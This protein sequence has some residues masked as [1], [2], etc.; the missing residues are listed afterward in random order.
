MKKLYTLLFTAAAFSVI[1][2]Q[3][4]PDDTYSGNGQANVNPTND[5]QSYNMDLKEMISL[6]G[7]QAVSM[8]LFQDQNTWE[9]WTEI[10][11]QIEDNGS[12]NESLYYQWTS[13]EGVVEGFSMDKVSTGIMLAGRI[14][15]GNQSTEIEMAKLDGNLSATGALDNTFG[16]NGKLLIPDFDG[17][18]IPVKVLEHSDGSFFL[19]TEVGIPNSW[20]RKIGISKITAAGVVDNT[21]GTNGHVTHIVGDSLISVNDALI[22]EN[23]NVYVG[24]TLYRYGSYDSGEGIFQFTSQRAFVARFLEDGTL[25]NS[26]SNDGYQSVSFGSPSRWSRLTNLAFFSN[27]EVLLTGNV[28][29]P[30]GSNNSYLVPGY[31]KFTSNGSYNSSFGPNNNGHFTSNFGANRAS[32]NEAIIVGNDNILSLG[33]VQETTNFPYLPAIFVMD[34]DGAALTTYHQDGYYLYSAEGE[35]MREIAETTDS[36]ILT[37]G[38]IY[39]Q[40]SMWT[41]TST[42]RFIYDGV[43]NLST[44]EIA[45]SVYPNPARD[46]LNIASSHNLEKVTIIGMDGKIARTFNNATSL[47]VEGIAPGSYILIGKTLSGEITRQKIIVE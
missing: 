8:H 33:S 37:Y 1:G 7:T 32:N 40:G 20:N 29:I 47:S 13:L 44:E 21:F 2:Q 31:A 10:H 38:S 23:D 12:I 30:V 22:D 34:A 3:I 45:F 18:P 39:D 25:D 41:E 46:V 28:I 19:I 26:Y 14:H 42:H 35:N 9:P 6:S 4:T 43:A 11:A 24:G 17:Y 15:D 16:T 36:K 5:G 27:G